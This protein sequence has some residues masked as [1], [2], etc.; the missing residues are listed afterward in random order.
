[1][2]LEKEFRP[3]IN[4]V[5]SC[6]GGSPASGCDWCKLYHMAL[7]LICV[8]ESA[9]I[10]PGPG[11]DPYSVAHTVREIYENRESD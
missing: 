9:G 10:S 2:L 8:A 7:A 4:F 6:G 5:C 11:V 3:L 1:V